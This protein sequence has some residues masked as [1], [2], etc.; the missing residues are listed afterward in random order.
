M[1]WFPT[2]TRTFEAANNFWLIRSGESARII[3][4]TCASVKFSP[5]DFNCNFTILFELSSKRVNQ[6]VTNH[7][8]TSS[9]SAIFAAL[10]HEQTP[11]WHKNCIVRRYPASFLIIL[12]YYGKSRSQGKLVLFLVSPMIF[13]VK[14]TDKLFNYAHGGRCVS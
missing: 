10:A 12:M 1:L 3:F 4:S 5:V 14:Q 13:N 8:D 2:L 11:L 7:V 6:K 9:T